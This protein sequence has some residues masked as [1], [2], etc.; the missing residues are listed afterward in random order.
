MRLLPFWGPTLHLLLLAQALSG[1]FVATSNQQGTCLTS[2][3]WHRFFFKNWPSPLSTAQPRL[4]CPSWETKGSW[5]QI[6]FR[7]W[8]APHT[9]DLAKTC[10]HRLLSLCLPIG[11]WPRLRS[12]KLSI[13]RKR[14]ACVLPWWSSR[15]A[16]QIDLH[17]E[18]LSWRC[19]GARRWW[20]PDR[21]SRGRS[22]QWRDNCR[23]KSC[24]RGHGCCDDC[25]CTGSFGPCASWKAFPWWDVVLCSRSDENI[26]V[27]HE[28]PYKVRR[29]WG[30]ARRG[31]KFAQEVRPTCGI[32]QFQSV[33]RRCV[34][35]R[36]RPGH[37]INREVQRTGAKRCGPAR[38]KWWRWHLCAR[39]RQHLWK[40]G[41]WLVYRGACAHRGHGIALEEQTCRI[42]DPASGIG[43]DP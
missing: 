33:P 19:W 17:W 43:Y 18:P 11:E 8:S 7:S 31:H 21:P 29:P 41:T 25:R 5:E 37:E 4:A 36:P 14:A 1:A 39:W 10:L 2:P 27:V 34:A 3:S 6:A 24:G 30:G 42:I 13:A 15:V 20:C 23:C 35:L 22:L 26:V 32:P 16:M 12:W 38:R 28:S 40:W 9:R